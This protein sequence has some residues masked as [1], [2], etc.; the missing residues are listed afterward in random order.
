MQDSIH[1]LNQIQIINVIRILIEMFINLA[2]ILTNGLECCS[3]IFVDFT[4]ANPFNAF[5]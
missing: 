2:L 1:K 4:N 3:R 5:Q